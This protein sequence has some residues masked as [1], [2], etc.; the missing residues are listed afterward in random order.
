MIDAESPEEARTRVSN[1]AGEELE[2]HLE[3]SHVLPVEN[4]SVEDKDGKLVLD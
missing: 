4:W 1:G 2:N 3:Y